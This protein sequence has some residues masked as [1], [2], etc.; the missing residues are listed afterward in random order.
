LADTDV[1]RIEKEIRALSNQLKKVLETAGGNP[2]THAQ[3]VLLASQI[4][5]LQDDINHITNVGAATSSADRAK[6]ALQQT[7]ASA[8]D[9]QTPIDPK[10]DAS[11][12][13]TPEASRTVRL[14]LTGAF[15][16]T[17]A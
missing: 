13:Q 15:I 16:D 8:A 3:A 12:T 6:A 5:S 2:V 17:T 9:S 1:Q 7:V 4:S 11:T 10:N 14:D